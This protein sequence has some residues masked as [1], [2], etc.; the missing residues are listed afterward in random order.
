MAAPRKILEG[1][2]D[3]DLLAA[4]CRIDTYA[5]CVTQFPAVIVCDIS[6]Q[7]FATKL[8]NGAWALWDPARKLRFRKKAVAA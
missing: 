2:T 6:G 7:L 4:G 5:S 3:A 8:T 1:V